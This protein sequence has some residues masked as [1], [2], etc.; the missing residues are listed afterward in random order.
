MNEI[1][2]GDSRYALDKIGE[3]AMIT[4]Y[5]IRYGWGARN[6]ENSGYTLGELD[7]SI[8]S[9]LRLAPQGINVTLF[10][11]WLWEVRNPLMLLA[12]IESFIFLSISIYLIFRLKWKKL[13]E[14]ANHPL[15]VYCLS[16][17]LLFAFAVG[18]S[19]YNFGTLMRYKIPVMPF[20]M[21]ALILL[22][23]NHRFK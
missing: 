12:A 20:Y 4:A 21:I 6:G 7:G 14:K 2:K 11:P 8:G 10:R 3:T 23:S 5:D 13:R 19:T 22:N 15:V 18:V 1:S 9:L 17:S 16:F